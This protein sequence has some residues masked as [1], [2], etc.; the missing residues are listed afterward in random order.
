MMSP[1]RRDVLRAGG[2]AALLSGGLAG[3][4]EDVTDAPGEERPAYADWLFDTDTLLDASFQGFYAVDVAAYREQQAAL[5]AEAN[6]AVQRAADEYDGVAVED[7][8]R[9]TGLG[10]F[11]DPNP[12]D[13]GDEQFILTTVGTGSFDSDAVASAIRS[14]SE[15]SADGEYEGYDLY[16]RRDRYSPGN[17]AAAAVGDEAVVLTVADAGGEYRNPPRG[18]TPPS[19]SGTPAG[20]VSA[21]RAVVHHVDAGASGSG[22]LLA[23]NDRLDRLAEALDGPIVGGLAFDAATLRERLGFRSP[24][25]TTATPEADGRDGNDNGG[26]DDR[27]ASTPTVSEPEPSPVE[28]HLRRV[29]MGLTAFGGSADADGASSGAVDFRLLYED[30]SAASDGAAAV[31]DLRDALRAESEAFTV[32]EVTVET[33]GTAVVVAITGDPSAFYEALGFGDSN[34]PNARAPQVSFTFDRRE[35]GRVT[36]THDGGD[37]V[38]TEGTIGLLYESNGEGIERQ[39]Q[40]DDGSITAG[41]SVTTDQPVTGILRVIWTS[42]EGGS[43]ATLGLYRPPEPSDAPEVAFGFETRSENRVAITHESGDHVEQPLVVVYDSVEGGRKEVWE[44]E[45]DAIA[46]GDTYTTELALAEDGSVR[47]IWDGEGAVTLAEYRSAP[48]G[49]PR[50]TRTASAEGTETQ[51]PQQATETR[52]GTATPDETPTRTP[53]PTESSTATT[54]ESGTP[55]TAESSTATPTDS[56]TATPTESGTATPTETS[57]STSTRTPTPVE[58]G[59]PTSGS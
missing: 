19:P 6:E 43:S 22:G 47:V 32:P 41:D 57:T 15:V 39:W 35:D 21:E 23:G 50:R 27:R 36:V 18:E 51:P 29:T 54:T 10:A 24:E 56:A 42:P 20:G 30:E 16:T 2:V 3:C 9:V 7:F 38:G 12:D 52:T 46:A 4:I 53:R 34:E 31:E 58:D 49:T 55:T 26:A 33:D 11:A 8:D 44:P 28:R 1:K 37:E 45:G 13:Y 40:P 59:T 5:P 25:A 14:N 48:T 17:T